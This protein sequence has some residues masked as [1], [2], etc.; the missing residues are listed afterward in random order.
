MASIST[1]RAGN[2]RIQF[3]ADDGKRKAINLGKV[4]LRK[5]EVWVR[6]IEQILEAKR[7]A[8]TVEPPTLAWVESLTD[9]LHCK[10]VLVG[11]MP[12]RES[13]ANRLNAFLD[14][15]I[16]GRKDVKPATK[17]VWRQVADALTGYFGGDRKLDSI[18]E[19]EADAFK[20]FLI[21]KGLAS[22][23]V[24]KRLQFTRMLFKQAVKH[25]IISRNPFAAVSATAVIPDSRKCFVERSTIDA[26]MAV[27]DT[28][29]KTI[30]AL[31]RY[32]GLRTPSETLS[33]T[34]EGIDWNKRRMLIP[35]P[36]TEHHPNGANRLM[37]IFPEL[38][39]Y[40]AE[41]REAAPE[42]AVFVIDER[43]RKPAITPNGWANANLRTHLVRLIN[44]A[45]LKTWPRLFHSLRV[46]RETELVARYPIH[47][48][49]HW[50]GNTPEIAMR[51]YLQV[52]ETDYANAAAGLDGLHPESKPSANSSAVFAQKAAQ[53][54]SA[55]FSTDSQT[56][57][58]VVTD[59]EVMRTDAISCVR[60]L[61]PRMEAGGIE[62]PSRDTS[63]PASTCL[64]NCCCLAQRVRR[65][66][67]C[68]APASSIF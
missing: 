41:A 26:L 51:H 2:R 10:L 65:R 55:G 40:L 47:V 64:A 34:W 50:L 38:L 7:F 30:L 66:P 43:F 53:H 61:T 59:K 57:L 23:T 11:L 20:Q 12:S 42:N 22:T 63:D 16:A 48:V 56:A 13:T 31:A 15:F 8:Q 4:A 1:D 27:C 58:Q 62:P 68:V 39:K 14:G 9:E 54:A 28:T 17:I 52:T 46:S 5:V 29:W 32:G 24:H 44:R 25:R 18:N 35:S 19:G 33:I 45:G 49:A 6:H 37:P 60:L 21:G 3:V 67:R 36:K